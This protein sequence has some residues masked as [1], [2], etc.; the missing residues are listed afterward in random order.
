MAISSI[1]IKRPVSVIML[2]IT[3]VG[4]GILGLKNMPVDLMPNMNVPV[5]MIQTTW[6]GATPE[7]MDS[8]V[9]RKIEEV[10]PNIEGIKEMNSTSSEN[11]SFVV[12][13]FDYGTDTDKKVTDVQTELNNIRNDLPSDIDTPI[14][15]KIQPGG[16][17]VIAVTVSAEDLISAKSL[18]ENRIKPRFQQILGVG[19]V[20]VYGGFEKEVK[21]EVDPNKIES[22]GMNIDDL[23][24]IIGQSSTNIPAG[25]VDEG[26]K[27]Y[28]IKVMSELKTVEE[29]QNI[30][31]SNEDGKAL[32][33]KDV[34][35]VK[36]GNKDVESYNRMN[37][38]PSISISVEKST[39]GNSVSISDGVK[40]AIKSLEQTLPS[41]VKLSV[42]Y[43]TSIDISNSI[44]NV[45]NSAIAGLILASIVLFVFLKDVRATIIIAMAI[46]LSIVGAFFLLNSIGVG[47]NII[48]LMGLSLGVGMLV[49]NG[50]VV[51][52][53]IY[54]HMTELKKPKFE[55][56]RDGASEMLVP[57]IASTATTVAVFLPIVMTEG[58]AKEVFWGMSW[59]VTFSLLA[60]LLVAM[61]FVPMISNKILK[62]KVVEVQDGKV[63]IFIKKRYVKLL[64]LTLKHKFKTLL[65]VIIMFFAIVIPGIKIVGGGFIPATDDNVYVVTG[66]TPPGVTL[67]K[68]DS[69]TR[70]VEKILDADKY[71]RNIETSVENDGFSINV[72]LDLRKDRDK[73]VFEITDIIREKLKGI[74]DVDLNVA[75]GYAKGPDSGGRDIELDLTS[76]NAGQLD[77]FAKLV[78]AEMKN[79]P[80]IGD[81]KSSLT[82]GSP[83]ARIVIDRE[84]AR[85]YGIRPADINKVI[86]YQVLGSNPIDLKTD[87]EEI[88]V[89]VMMPD[90]YRKS[91]SKL[92]TS[93]LKLDSGDIIQVSDVAHIEVVEGPAE[94]EKLNRI[95][96]VT[97]SAN[98]RGGNN[99]KTV[100]NLI[101]EKIKEL[102]VPNSV[103]YRFGGDN[104]RTSE[105]MVQL[106][107][108]MFIAIFLIFVILASQFESLVLPFIIM[109]SVP[110]SIMGV[111]A[112]LMI[113]GKEFNVMVMVG[114]IM[115]AGIVVNNALVLIDYIKL[116]IARGSDR[117]TA[118]LEAGRTRLRP[119]LM[120]TL[121]TMLGM[122]PLALG[123]GQ[124][125]EMY[126]S[127]AIAVIFG[128]MISTLLTL[129]I[130][131]VLYELVENGVDRV[132]AKFKR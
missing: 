39:D 74:P 36:L 2:M 119:I 61:T 78:F 29:V 86:F 3:M 113:T 125:S 57:I 21:V 15:K 94:K 7:D 83:E 47:L 101:T 41:D 30:V 82:G 112:G 75:D 71:T 55:S 37:G 87:L 110:L 9:T 122:T 42:S 33:L 53:N 63:L 84:K 34:A 19:N 10:M 1:A 114:I 20:E 28:L 79:M 92:M 80:E 126:Q 70:R 72:K 104:Q 96:K 62:E 115:L 100:E 69:I 16:E 58:L 43:D 103:A 26:E 64:S 118:V 45:K 49:D 17:T 35:D 8:L 111:Y 109:G 85:Y 56:A 120:T 59:A 25:T 128:L 124:G 68:V 131:P 102:G 129:V 54:R 65:V 123:I 24:D 99:S 89:N 12:L 130:I 73:S 66:E 98:L 44:N 40:E 51:L 90:E 105:M 107:N 38:T 116:L 95:R 121:T 13:E 93:K 81:F 4:M 127:M 52:D 6:I 50:V 117:R 88:E 132:K 97:L 60:S 11:S 48:S 106:K 108:S 22:Y 67:D 46:P 91:L 27:R 77:S 18:A 5:V 32:Y 14:V 23:Y 31:I 76:D